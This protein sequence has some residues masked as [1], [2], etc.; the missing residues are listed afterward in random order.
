[1]TSHAHSPDHAPD[2]WH[3]HT[4][5]APPSAAHAEQ[6]NISMVLISG[7]VGF[8]VIVVCIALTWVYFNAYKTSFQIQRESFPESP[9][10]GGS[11]A[12]A[13]QA[14]ALSQRAK[15][16]EEVLKR[17]PGIDSTTG[18]VLIGIQTA[19]QRVIQRYQAMTR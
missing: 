5:E 6:I 10:A 2:A 14:E 18:E 7:V 1:M 17:R 11:A 12:L 13:I 19:G 16:Q 3:D 15:V 9:A 4:G 8:A